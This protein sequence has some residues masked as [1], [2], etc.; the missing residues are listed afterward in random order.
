MIEKNNSEINLTRQA[1]LL[2]ISRSGIY[3]QPIIDP[4]EIQIKNAIDEIYTACP[5]YGSRKIK[6]QLK[7]EYKIEISR[8]YVQNLM[9]AMGLQ[10]IYP[11]KRLNLSAGNKQ[12][13]K[14]PY[15]LKNLEIVRVNQVWSTDITYIRLK[16]GFAYLTVIFD[17]YSRYVVSWKLSATLENDFCIQALK[18]ALEIAVPEIHNSDQGVQFTAENYTAVLQEKNIQISMDGRGRCM[19]NIFTERLWRTVK[20][21]NIYLHDYQDIKEARAGLAQYFQFYNHRR[22]HQSLDYLTP[23][24]IYLPDN[25]LIF[26]NQIHL[27]E[28]KILS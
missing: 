3:Y 17:W 22:I 21:E 25:Q 15:L 19:D 16:N 2:D 20:Y 6:R 4:R 1:E 23:A 9:R 7:L 28:A 10:A 12:H 11:A 14:Y 8:G 24:E 18:E 5:F 27:I 13:K 26:K